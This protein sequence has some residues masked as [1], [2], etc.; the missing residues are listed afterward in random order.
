[1]QYILPVRCNTPYA[2][3]IN[4]YIRSTKIDKYVKLIV[5]IPKVI[6]KRDEMRLTYRSEVKTTN[7]T[8]FY[9]ISSVKDS[10]GF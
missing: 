2:T 3:K 1:M 8:V 5:N 6:D 10:S 7:S 4:V 9:D